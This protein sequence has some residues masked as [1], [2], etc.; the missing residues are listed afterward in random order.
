VRRAAE[1]NP[2]KESIMS[3]KQLA[4]EYPPEGE[5]QVI[6]DLTE[7][8][9]KKIINEN[10][11]GIM[12]R[13][14]HTKMHG[15]VK[16]E[17]TVLPDLPPELQVGLFQQPGTYQAWLRFSN[18]NLMNPD[19][20]K[21][22]RGVA[23]KVMQVPGPKLM[24]GE[25]DSPNVDFVLI[26]SPFFMAR[27]VREFDDLIKGLTGGTLALLGFFLSHWRMSWNLLRS[28]KSFANPL[29]IRYWSATPYL[30][31]SQAVKYSVIP[32]VDQPEPIPN[33][34]PDDLLRQAMIRQL[35]R[36][37]AYF[38]FAVQFQTDAERMPIEDPG[39]EW[40]EAESPFRTVARIK[41]PKQAFDS[42]AQ[43]EFGENASF[44]PAR[45]LPEQRPLGGINRARMVVY[46]AISQFRHEKNQ[47]AIK[48]PIGWEV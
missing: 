47:V 23:L 21:D 30:F 9:I 43:R 48:E 1:D 38:D 3:R 4:Q 8:Q 5:A 12:R 28:M 10:P 44:N 19:I 18:Q 14:A 22:I 42:A 39:V 20:K 24:P 7:R 32:Q 6:R 13:D 41:I 17:F 31:G 26:S 33:P 2:T 46:Q 45:C 15:M 29:Q 35:A 27:D 16:A 25:P 36:E 11:S 37:D 40:S 34:A